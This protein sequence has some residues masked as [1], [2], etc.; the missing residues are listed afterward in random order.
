MQKKNDQIRRF[1]AK[2]PSRSEAIS[3]GKKRLPLPWYASIS[4]IKKIIITTKRNRRTILWL[5]ATTNILQN[6]PPPTDTI[7]GTR[8]RV[9][10]SKKIP[11][12]TRTS[13]YSTFTIENGSV[14]NPCFLS[15]RSILA[16]SFWCLS[17]T[18][19]SRC[20][21]SLSLL[22]LSFACRFFSTAAASLRPSSPASLSAL[23]RRNRHRVRVVQ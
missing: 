19:A 13:L 3:D 20:L 8:N 10:I 11:S 6:S 5:T 4:L 17:F 21:L 12:K 9:K 23:P 18:A 15:H 1:W 16:I 7:S 2:E 22:R 14:A